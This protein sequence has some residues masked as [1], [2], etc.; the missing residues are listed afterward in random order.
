MANKTTNYELTKPLAEEFY[1]VEDQNGNM[2]II[3][4]ELKK[5]ADSIAKVKSVS[6]VVT[7]TGT[8]AAYLASVSYT[9]LRAHET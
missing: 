8:G 5:N 2:D 4:A 7:T 1:N 9:H 6:A 3:D